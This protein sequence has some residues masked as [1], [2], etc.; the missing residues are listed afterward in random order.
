MPRV[1]I[2]CPQPHIADANQLARC[3]GL[4]PDDEKTYGA[5]AWQDALGNLYAVASAVVGDGFAQAAGSTLSAPAWGCNMAAAR[6][7][8]ALIQ[9]GSAASPDKL[10]AMFGDDAIAAV[11]ALGLS[12]VA[13]NE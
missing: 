11:A 9:I 6:R 7:A 3:I 2:A 8:Q 1:T 4:G 12:A 10:S 13:Q 5:A